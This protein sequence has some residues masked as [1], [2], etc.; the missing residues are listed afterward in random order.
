MKAITAFFFIE[1]SLHS[2]GASL[3]TNRH[4]LRL[5]LVMSVPSKKFLAF[6]LFL[7]VVGLRVL[8]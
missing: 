6:D 8:I 3:N 5:S 4:G 1:C 2:A 7:Q